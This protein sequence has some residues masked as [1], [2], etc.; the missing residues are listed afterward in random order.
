MTPALR[1]VT[2]GFRGRLVFLL[3]WLTAGMAAGG[4]SGRAAVVVSGPE[5]QPV[6]G[7]NAVVTW[8]TDAAT[9]GVVRYGLTLGGLDQ[10]VEEETVQAK[11]SVRLTGLRPGLRY[12]YVVSTAR[13][14]L[15]TNTFVMP[16]LMAA[17]PRPA[18]PTAPPE[19]SPATTPSPAREGRDAVRTVSPTRA[20][21]TRQ[22]WGQV[23]SLQDHFDRHG[24]DFAARDPDDYARQ[25]WEFLQRAR[26]E[27]LPAKIDD[28]GVVRI[29]D[30]RTGAFAAYN[31]N[32]TTK[33][34]F[35]PNSRGYFE[36]QPGRPIDAR[37]LK[38]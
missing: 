31:R 1:Q 7:T 2:R 38:F 26:R 29:F 17:S 12:H 10:T 32:G 23:A 34:Y 3:L 20:P 25:A 6:L 4:S 35:K 9:R 33:T 14:P 15:A 24:A 19:V 30:S 18:S 27:G 36:R 5:V 37:T 16:G 28:D 8:V 13:V 11:H 22:T 21:P